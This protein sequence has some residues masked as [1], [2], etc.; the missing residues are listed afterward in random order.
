[1]P[2]PLFQFPNKAMILVIASRGAALALGDEAGRGAR[3]LSNLL[4]LNW[5]YQEAA[6]G[7]NWFRNLL[8]YGG[9]AYSVGMLVTRW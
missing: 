4:L 7:D 1:M 5:A 9:V 3:N 8:G 2:R 6:D